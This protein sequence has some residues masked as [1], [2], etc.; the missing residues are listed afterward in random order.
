[1]KGELP[2]S[3]RAAWGDAAIAHLEG[4][5]LDKASFASA[6]RVLARGAVL[7]LVASDRGLRPPF[8]ASSGGDERVQAYD[9]FAAR[10]DRFGA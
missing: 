10:L 7:P 6:Q 5:G 8:T 4:I 9:A 3:S 1:M 2:S